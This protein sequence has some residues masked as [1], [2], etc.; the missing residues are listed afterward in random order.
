MVVSG[1]EL[2][3]I[4]AMILRPIS[5]I[6]IRNPSGYQWEAWQKFE[7]LDGSQVTIYAYGWTRD[8]MMEMFRQE[9]HWAEIER[10]MD[11]LED[12]GNVLWNVAGIIDTASSWIRRK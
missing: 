8:V 7:R 6:T 12:I 11:L 4:K 5:I 3:H 1:I 9:K 2:S 10:P